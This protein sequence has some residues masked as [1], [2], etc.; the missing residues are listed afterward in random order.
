MKDLKKGIEAVGD[1]ITTATDLAINEIVAEE[2]YD[3]ATRCREVDAVMSASRSL[4][5]AFEKWA[6]AC[7]GKD[8]S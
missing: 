4:G 5:Y 1:C 6:D 7:T 2:T 3:A 8:N